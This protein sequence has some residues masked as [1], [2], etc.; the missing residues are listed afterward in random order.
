MDAFIV[1]GCDGSAGKEV[2]EGGCEVRDQ[3]D[4]DRETAMHCRCC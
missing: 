4:E 1:G 3:D 2:R